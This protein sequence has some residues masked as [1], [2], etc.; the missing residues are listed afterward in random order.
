MQPSVPLDLGKLSW[1]VTQRCNGGT[2]VRVASIGEQVLI[3]DSK[4]PSGPVLSY[5]R[6]EW[7]AFVA[8]VKQ[9]DF[10]HLV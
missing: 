5:S 2:C 7:T 1:Q 4:S 8:G 10:D 9:G 3:G 6:D